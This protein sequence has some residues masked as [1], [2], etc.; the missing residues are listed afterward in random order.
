MRILTLWKQ[1]H[2]L[3]IPLLNFL[4]VMRSNG[5][6]LPPSVYSYYK[7]YAV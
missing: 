2:V 5:I 7:D 4:V 6:L 3:Y 1:I